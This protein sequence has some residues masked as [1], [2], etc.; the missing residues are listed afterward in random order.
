[1]FWKWRGWKR[2]VPGV[3]GK[4]LVTLGGSDPHGVTLKAMEALG[5]VRLPGV[6]AVGVVGAGNSRRAGVGAA[7]PPGEGAVR[8]RSD[9]TDMP[10]LMAWADV[11]VAAGGTTTWERALLGLPSLIVVLAENQEELAEAAA[12]AGLGWNL[13]RYEA[14][15][16]SAL[17]D[18]LGRLLA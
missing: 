11:A 10:E 18:A 14:L 7:A 2:H 15:E 16:V 1:E 9:V 6:E 3:A 12:R 8:L 17:A 4:M 5:R 13:G